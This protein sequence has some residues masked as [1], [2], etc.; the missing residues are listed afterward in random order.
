MR[1]LG[2]SGHG[3][4]I[5]G[6]DEPGSAPLPVASYHGTNY[7]YTRGC[8][9]DACVDAL[10]GRGVP[11]YVPVLVDRDLLSDLLH[12]LFP[13]GLTNDCPLAHLRAA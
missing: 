8:R 4:A 5:S 1:T 12:E 6:L 7:G 10:T 11:T 3:R 2:S 13:F 9:C